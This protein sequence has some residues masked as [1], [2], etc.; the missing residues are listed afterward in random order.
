MGRSKSRAAN[1][2]FTIDL[3][4][5]T[6]ASSDFQQPEA[7][8]LDILEKAEAR[9]LDMVA[10]TDHNTVSGYRK[11][12][13]EIHQ[14]ELLERLGRLLSEERA[15]LERYRRL[16]GKVLVLPGF[17]F[18]ATFGFHIL[19]IFPPEKP[20][21][22]GTRRRNDGI[23]FS[24]VLPCFVEI[25]NKSISVIASEAKQSRMSAKSKTSGSPRRFAPRD[26]GVVQC[27]LKRLGGRVFSS[28]PFAD[29][30]FSHP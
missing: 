24:L 12:T 28:R 3:H 1:Q 7:T 18:T 30:K 26:D 8:Y 6:P 10:F 15:R 20:V 14:L 25:L 17:E 19:C 23:A 4:I 9:S 11:M 5:H 2:W 27:F 21:R 22:E 29:N 16:M 13:D